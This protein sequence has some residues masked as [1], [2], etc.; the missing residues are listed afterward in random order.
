MKKVVLFR[1]GLGNQIFQYG[2]Y[3]WQK[4]IKHQNVCYYYSDYDHNGFELN[5]YFDVNLKKASTFYSWL[6]W[7]IWRLNKYGICKKFMYFEGGRAQKTAT[8][9]CGGTG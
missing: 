5:K 2:M 4:S 3:T 7:L 9:L 8:F 6:Y 1:G